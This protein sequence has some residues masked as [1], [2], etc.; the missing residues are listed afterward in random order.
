M[1]ERTNE[2]A[3]YAKQQGAIERFY[4]RPFCSANNRDD[5]FHRS[6]KDTTASRA[7]REFR[8]FG[9]FKIMWSSVKQ[10][11]KAPAT[12]IT[13][14]IGPE[15]INPLNCYDPRCPRYLPRPPV[16]RYR[17]PCTY[18]RFSFAAFSW[19]VFA[20]VSWLL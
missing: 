18:M 6:R 17:G 13:D 1:K 15:W 14:W 16:S 2:Y 10:K 8:W 3:M 4:Q 7:S 11:G 19:H 12:Y 20:P 9:L 5:Q